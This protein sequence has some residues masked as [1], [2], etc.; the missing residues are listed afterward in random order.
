MYVICSK[1]GCDNLVKLP[2]RYC[3]KHKHVEKEL[4][5][6]KSNWYNKD[7]DVK[8]S[9][10]VKVFYNSKAWEVMREV[11]LNIDN[12]LCQDCYKNGIIKQADVVH[13]KKEL[14][15]HWHLRLNKNNL[16]SLCHDCHNKIHKKKTDKNSCDINKRLTRGVM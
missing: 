3:K 9:E 11:R 16:I 10:E 4:K 5:K 13:H 6:K 1:V 7:Y 8:R 12:H 2:D 15:T 14:R